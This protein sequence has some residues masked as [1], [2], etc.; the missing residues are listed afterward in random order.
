MRKFVLSLAAAGTALAFASPASAQTKTRKDKVGDATSNVDI[1]SA[2]VQNN[3]RSY[4]LT[5]R[6]QKVQKRRTAVAVSLFP[7]GRLDRARQH[8]PGHGRSQRVE[9]AHHLP[10][11]AILGGVHRAC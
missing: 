3:A 11:G 6:F 2:K 5:V 10:L 4:G 7:G 9:I 8:P 1:R